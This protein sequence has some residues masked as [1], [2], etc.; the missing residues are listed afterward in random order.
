MEGKGKKERKE[1]ERRE[2]I[3]DKMG[4]YIGKEEGIA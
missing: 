1:K 2:K 3:R 4:R